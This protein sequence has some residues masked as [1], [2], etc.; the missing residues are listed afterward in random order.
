MMY[1]MILTPEQGDTII[2]ALRLWQHTNGSSTKAPDRSQ[3]KRVAT[4]NG[5]H[6]MH[7]EDE[8]EILISYISAMS[9]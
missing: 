4:N 2:A 3:L 7:T 9:I 1:E 8:I 5:K 6:P